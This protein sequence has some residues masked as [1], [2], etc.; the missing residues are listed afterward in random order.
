MTRYN[1]KRATS[2]ED[3]A[4]GVCLRSDLHLLLDSY[5]MVFYPVQDGFVAYFFDLVDPYAGQY[6]RSVINVH[7]RV[8]R[9]HLYAR[10][11]FNVIS[12]NR[13]LPMPHIPTV[14]L[15]VEYINTR[16]R[17][18]QELPSKPQMKRRSLTGSVLRTQAETESS[19]TEGKCTW[20]FDYVAPYSETVASDDEMEDAPVPVEKL[21]ADWHA[22]NPQIRQ[23]S[24]E[25]ESSPVAGSMAS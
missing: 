8:A 21:I 6:H 1:L 25:S 2:T 16:A 14:A 5:S 19:V 4:N 7:P 24:G 10:F 11:A 18:A 3:V 20:S 15:S 9:A 13:F 22:K 12:H 17:G 23:T